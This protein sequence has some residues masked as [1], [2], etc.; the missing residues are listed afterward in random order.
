MRAVD[1]E[2]RDGARRRA[3]G[4]HDVGALQRGR[5]AVVAL[6]RDGAVGAEGA[7]AVVDVDLAGLHQPG[8]AL[9]EAVD[10]RCLRAWLTAKS[11]VRLAGLDAELLGPGDVAVHRRRLEELLGRD[12]APVEARAADLV[13]LHARHLQ[14]GAG[15]VERGGVA[16]RTTTD[17]HQVVLLGHGG[18]GSGRSSFHCRCTPPTAK[19]TYRSP[20]P[21]GKATA[22]ST[23][24][25]AS[26]AVPA[27]AGPPPDGTVTGA[28]AARV[29]GH[30]HRPAVPAS[31]RRSLAV[32][33]D[34][35]H[36]DV[37]HVA[38]CR[39]PSPSPDRPAG[40]GPAP[41]SRAP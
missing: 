35:H 29:A 27:H 10:D 30:H 9:P 6:H 36:D 3:G 34:L 33:V 21:D 28:R 18:Q 5:R 39:S 22:Q 40:S 20:S 17:H 11:T 15:A 41:G 2:A 14:P 37:A 32:Q 16:A 31:A 38:C 4:E 1:V 25:P 13:L 12:A 26:T 19:A 23:A 7:D 8:E 24:W